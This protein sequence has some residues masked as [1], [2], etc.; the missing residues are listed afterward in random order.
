MP[1]IDTRLLWASVGDV[2]SFAVQLSRWENAGILLK[3]KRGMYV[4]ADAYRKTEPYMPYV[5]A[6]LHKPSY[7][8]L[9]KALEYHGLVPE[10][11]L[12]WTSVTTKRPALYD[13]PIG[14]FSYRH[15][16]KELF[17]GYQS[18]S[19]NGWRGF[20]ALPEKALLDYFYFFNGEVTAEFI[21]EMRFQN[22]DT[23][24]RARMHAFASRFNKPKLIRAAEMFEAH[25][26]EALSGEK[27]L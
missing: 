13:T 22:L 21:D 27:T 12:V 15:V 1:V 24:D 8:S 20:M 2:H 5:A 11:I 3:L 14:R 25:A 17:W 23:V 19:G 26:Q 10:A 16:K 6:Q 9:E 7:I 4:L 18:V